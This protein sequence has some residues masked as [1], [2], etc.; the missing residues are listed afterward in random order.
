MTTNRGLGDRPT[1]NNQKTADTMSAIGRT[2][3]GRRVKAQK[4]KADAKKGGKK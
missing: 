4:D 1:A 3:R 2:A